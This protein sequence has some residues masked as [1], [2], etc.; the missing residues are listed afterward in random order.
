MVAEEDD[1]NDDIQ[2]SDV[3]DDDKTPHDSDFSDALS[4][5]RIEQSG[6]LDK[7]S[8]DE[9]ATRPS[10][11][12]TEKRSGSLVK[13]S[14]PSKATTKPK[15]SMIVKQEDSTLKLISNAIKS[16][17]E[18][19]KHVKSNDEFDTYGSFIASELRSVS[20]QFMRDK[21]KHEISQVFFNAKW[22]SRS[23]AETGNNRMPKQCGSEYSSNTI[24]QS[25]INNVNG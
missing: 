16:S 6:E 5:T 9:V 7:D 14:L 10:H 2:L 22:S 3:N 25:G 11:A 17:T 24:G 15:K 23:S 13:S 21:I 19:A 4:S 18:Q 1:V 12:V 8:S 20:D